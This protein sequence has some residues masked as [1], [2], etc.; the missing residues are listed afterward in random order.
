MGEVAASYTQ[1]PLAPRL[2]VNEVYKVVKS[3]PK[4]SNV[5]KLGK[6][7]PGPSNVV[8]GWAC[9]AFFVRYSV[10]L[11]LNDIGRCRWICVLVIT[12]YQNSFVY[13]L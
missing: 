12:S 1:H 4:R 9:S 6:F 3:E 7:S 11:K 13:G 2:E 5:K 10:E 8:P